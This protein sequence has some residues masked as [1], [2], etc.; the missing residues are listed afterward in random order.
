M[1]ERIYSALDWS[2]CFAASLPI[3]QK[4]KKNGMVALWVFHWGRTPPRLVVR[5]TALF[6]LHTRKGSRMNLEYSSMC[7]TTR[8]EKDSEANKVV[9]KVRC[10]LSSTRPKL[11]LAEN[12]GMP[13]ATPQG[14]QGSGMGELVLHFPRDEQG[15]QPT[16]VIQVE[17]G[18]I[19]SGR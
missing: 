10:G 13:L 11:R 3:F 9:K 18:S 4:K 17:A 2:C 14:R 8:L 19:R 6:L 15:C 16:S 7:K 12:I 5:P 1:Q